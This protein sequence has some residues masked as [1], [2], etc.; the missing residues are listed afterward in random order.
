MIPFRRF[1]RP[2][3]VRW[4]RIV[5]PTTPFRKWFYRSRLRHFKLRSHEA[6]WLDVLF[7]RRFVD[8][9][10]CIKKIGAIFEATS[11]WRNLP[12]IEDPVA[13]R[14][15]IHRDAE[16]RNPQTEQPRRQG[17]LST[18][19]THWPFAMIARGDYWSLKG[20]FCLTR[21][22]KRVK[23]KRVRS[24][25]RGRL[26]Q[27][28]ETNEVNRMNRLTV[29]DWR[30]SS[31]TACSVPQP[32]RSAPLGYLRLASTF[33][34]SRAR[35]PVC[36][37]EKQWTVMARVRRS[38]IHRLASGSTTSTNFCSGRGR[39][40]VSVFVLEL[41]NPLLDRPND[42]VKCIIPYSSLTQ[43]I[44]FSLRIQTGSVGQLRRR[45]V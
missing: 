39:T 41:K 43:P 5:F 32:R 4:F 16:G 35:I 37:K 21:E 31:I 26:L 1:P 9:L 24:H 25:L 20:L 6:L 8:G 42:N 27:T 12:L 38:E 11:I 3:S 30:C 36:E 19:N 28:T 15:V 40:I 10:I 13:G 29:K 14:R 33:P 22:K 45:Q 44:A 34:D 17:S 18:N 23:E 2:D 7:T